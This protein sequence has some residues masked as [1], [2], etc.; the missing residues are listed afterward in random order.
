MLSNS[1][2]VHPSLISPTVFSHIVVLLWCL[3]YC[4]KDHDQKQ[5]GKKG[6]ISSYTFMS[7]SNMARSQRSN[8]SR[9]VESG[10]KVDTMKNICMLSKAC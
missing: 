2:L 7:Q 1:C 9:S 5:W 4:N 10:L 6:L 8:S 3:C